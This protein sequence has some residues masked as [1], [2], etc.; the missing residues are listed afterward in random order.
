L[1]AVTEQAQQADELRVAFRHLEDFA[2]QMQT[3]L[4]TAQGE[5]KRQ[6]LRAL[7]KRVEVDKDTLRLVY[8]VPLHPFAEGPTRGQLQDCGARQRCND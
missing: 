4:A 2:E 7:L 6:I 5:Q 1:R 3:G 8:R